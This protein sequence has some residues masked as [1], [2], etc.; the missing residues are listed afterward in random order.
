ML[1]RLVL[2]HPR[3]PPQEEACRILGGRPKSTSPTAFQKGRFT[4]YGG[5]GWALLERAEVE[6]HRDGEPYPARPDHHRHSHRRAA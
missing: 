3:R 6:A 5:H 1:V 4:R 2:G